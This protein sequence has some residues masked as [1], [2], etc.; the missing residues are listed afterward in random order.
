M[1]GLLRAPRVRGFSMVEL[2][3][4]L[5]L[6][7]LLSAVL[8]GALG[9]AGRS[10]DGGEAKVAQTSE[11]RQSLA[12]L[13]TQLSGLYPQRMRKAA[14]V[15]LWFA[16]TEDEVRYTAPLPERVVDGGVFYFRLRLD[17]EVEPAQLVLERHRF[18]MRFSSFRDLF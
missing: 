2:M 17:R 7:A 5:S 1:T 12:F 6:L 9:L 15:P 13:R 18:R 11:M 16:G 14:E 3:V 8:F 4:A 10:W